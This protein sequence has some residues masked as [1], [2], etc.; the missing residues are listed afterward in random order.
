M[1][2]NITVPSIADSITSGVISKWHKKDGDFVN[3]DEELL[4][5]ETDK[6]TM[7]ILAPE[8]GVLKRSAS[9]GDTVNVGQVIGAIEA[10]SAGAA[11]KPAPAAAKAEAASPTPPKASAPVA[12]APAPA[13]AAPAPKASPAPTTNGSAAPSANANSGQDVFATPLAKKL[14]AEHNVDLSRLTGTGGA[15]RIREQDVLAF[16]QSRGSDAAPSAARP[17]SPAAAP[18]AGATREK[19]T[20][21]R[22]RIAQRLVQAQHAAAMLTTFNE[23]DMGA[24]MDLRKSYK[25]DFEKKHGIGLGFMGFFVKATVSALKAFPMVNAYIVEEAGQLMIEKHP[26]CD[27]AVAVSTPKGLV[28]PV[29]RQCESRSMAQ[30]ESGIKDLAVRGRDG[31][32]G[33]DE[34]QGGT[35]TITNGGVFGSLLSTPILNAPQ[36]AILGMHT[37]KNRPAEYPVGSGQVAIRPMMYLA[38][39]YDHR[40]IDGAEAVQFLV[41][42]K[43]NIEDPQRLL[44]EI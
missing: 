22:Q 37:I 9:E 39:S 31:K 36:S 28:V 34:M 10:G 2:T 33:L 3:R 40:I 1:P 41:R 12:V 26:S 38:L 44:L 16:V 4:D 6:V 20:P 14:A 24:V 17:S 18:S 42:I 15:G 30:I 27:I 43:Q 32:L 29:L 8:A 23:V 21:L 25:E 5:L 19:M 13:V 35:F 11:S 7:P